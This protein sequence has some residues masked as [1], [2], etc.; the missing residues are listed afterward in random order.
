MQKKTF[1]LCSLLGGGSPSLL[2]G[3]L[4]IILLVFAAR[5]IGLLQGIELKTL[6]LF[7]R[8]RPPESMDKR[9][10]ILEINDTDI[11]TLGTYP[12]PDNIIKN[13]LTDL[14]TYNPRVI[15]LDIFRDIPVPNPF[16]AD[17]NIEATQK[18]NEALI[19]LLQASSD[20]IAIE[21]LLNDPVAAPPGVSPEKIGF[22]DALLD[23]DGF[24]RRSLLASPHPDNQSLHLSLT[25]Q[26]A[27]KYLATEGIELENGIRDKSAM[28]FGST[29]LFRLRSNSGGYFNQDTGNNPVILINFRSNKQPFNRITLNQF[30]SG[31]V[32]QDWLT[33]RIILIGMTAA[34]TKDYVNSAAIVSNNPGLV[35]GVE[36]QAHA[37]SQIVSAVLDGRPII[38]TWPQIWEYLWI[39]IAGLLGIGL[40]HI[41]CSILSAIALFMA[42]GLLP[43]I[44]GYGLILRGIWLPVFPVWIVYI[45]NGSSALLYGVY[46]H[47]QSWRIRLDERQRLIK[48]SYNTIHNGPL[49]TLKGLMRKVSSTDTDFSYPKLH[50]ELSNIDQELREIHEYMQQGYMTLE[51][52]T[53]LTSEDILDLQDPLHELLYQVYRSKLLELPSA[54]K[55]RIKMPDFCPLNTDSLTSE[56]KEDIIRFLE[57]ALGN[58][59]QHATKV[60]QL[61]VT[62][63]QEGDQNI[64]RVTN[65]G[66]SRKKVS[67]DVDEHRHGRGTKQA[68][69][70]ESRLGGHFFREINDSEGAVCELRWPVHQPSLWTKLLRQLQT[71]AK[72]LTEKSS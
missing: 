26:L 52:Q 41:R 5:L 8:W 50:K 68:K 36:L 53:Y 55:I 63:K 22:A 44:V 30:M 16:E 70:L 20:I 10:T 58:I 28:R 25:I 24:V 42:L 57:E 13:L 47:E 31:E 38:R 54:G 39:A 35:P 1:R 6:D 17:G 34:S 61:A 66:I 27:S 49:Q 51:T 32:P 3:G 59:E 67:A 2:L 12:V 4:G 23:A 21:K 40:I 71:S 14:K 33:D 18:S 29:E 56:D 72:S 60:T 19:E 64:V 15:G 45:L 46:Q 37:V 7:L 11:Q 65:N 69:A 43:P 62:C 48:Q 9:I